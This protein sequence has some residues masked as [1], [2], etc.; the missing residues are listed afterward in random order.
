MLIVKYPHIT[1]KCQITV[2][3]PHKKCQI[4]ITNNLYIRLLN[5]KTKCYIYLR[6]FKN[7]ISSL[8]AVIDKFPCHPRLVRFCHNLLKLACV[9]RYAQ[10]KFLCRFMAGISPNFCRPTHSR[11]K[12][13]KI[14]GLTKIP[15]KTPRDACGG[16]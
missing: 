6:K 14:R 13:P 3:T 15:N 11:A 5:H 4:T 8:L 7:K 9:S 12:P 2:S 1:K 10:C 16:G